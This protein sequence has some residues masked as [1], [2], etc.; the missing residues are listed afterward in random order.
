MDKA[1]KPY[2]GVKAVLGEAS[3]AWEKLAGHIRYYYA[4]DEQWVEGK[5][6]HRNYNNLF[7]RRSGKSFI[8]LGVREGFFIVCIVFGKAEREKFE[9]QRETFS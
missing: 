9:Q 2:E 3:P 6:A 4:M 7:V 5:P 8:I 1:I